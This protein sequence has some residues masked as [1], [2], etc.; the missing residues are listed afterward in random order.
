MEGSV[1]DEGI[2]ACGELGELYDASDTEALQTGLEEH[3]WDRGR[4]ADA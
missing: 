4:S 1:R 3:L 2:D